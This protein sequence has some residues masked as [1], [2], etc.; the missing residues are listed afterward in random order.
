MKTFFGI[1]LL[2]ILFNFFISIVY[3]ILYTEIPFKIILNKSF[4]LTLALFSFIGGF[5]LIL[6]NF[7]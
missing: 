4:M 6:I 1:I 5:V 2:F 3:K 7:F